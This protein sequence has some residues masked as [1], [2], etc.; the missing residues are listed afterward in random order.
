MDDEYLSL[1]ID[2]HRRQ[3]RQ[4]PGGVAETA[5]AIELAALDDSEPLAVADI[6]CGT[7]ASSLQLASVLNAN[8]AAVDF[9][10]DFIEELD[11]RAAEAGLSDHIDTQV[12]NMEALTFEEESLDLIWSE[13]AIYNMGFEKGVN[14]WRRFLRPGGRLVVSEITWLTDERPAELQA[15]WDSGYPE[16]ATASE[17]IAVLEKAGYTPM[18]YFALPSY[19][20]LEN[21]YTPLAA[22][23]TDF[24]MRHYDSDLAKKI[25]EEDTTEI[26]QYQRFKA[27]Y[28]YGMYVARKL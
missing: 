19:C 11:K 18:G 4:G 22:G 25:V 1:L 24:L 9:L 20:W 13:G 21:Y 5:R 28:S 12:A 7:G 6:G 15:F 16:I 27:Y 2:L 10:P 3:E 26:E 8:I 23:F 14:E 17:K